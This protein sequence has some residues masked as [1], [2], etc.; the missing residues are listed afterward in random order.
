MACD[1]PSA[2][3]PI[4]DVRSAVESA[5]AIR[6]LRPDV[7]YGERACRRCLPNVDHG[8]LVDAC[9]CFPR[10]ADGP[11]VGEADLS[12]AFSFSDAVLGSSSLGGGRRPREPSPDRFREREGHR[13]PLAVGVCVASSD[14]RRAGRSSTILRSTRRGSERDGASAG[15]SVGGDDVDAAPVADWVDPLLCWLRVRMRS[16]DRIEGISMCTQELARPSRR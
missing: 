4:D 10:H 12:S 15:G 14:P 11:A 3:L 7:P 2:T 6:E 8:E 1:C 13:A 5:L 16:R 9:L